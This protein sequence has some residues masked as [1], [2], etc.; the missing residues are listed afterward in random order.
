MHAFS[1]A[2]CLHLADLPLPRGLVLGPQVRWSLTGRD[3]LHNSVADADRRLL[4]PMSGVAAAGTETCVNVV[5]RV[6]V[7]VFRPVTADSVGVAVSVAVG[8]AIAMLSAC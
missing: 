1:V 5:Y 8:V 4:V 6:S 2:V 3:V 7:R